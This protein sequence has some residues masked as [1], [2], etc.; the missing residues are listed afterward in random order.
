MLRSLLCACMFA[1]FAIGCAESPNNGD[2]NNNVR[3]RQVPNNV[4]PARPEG[5]PPAPMPDPDGR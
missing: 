3:D 2:R 1:L 4:P 5:T